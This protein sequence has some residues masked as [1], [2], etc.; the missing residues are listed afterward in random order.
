MEV[1]LWPSVKK[2]RAQRSELAQVDEACAVQ[3]D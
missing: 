1:K 2:Q 3:A